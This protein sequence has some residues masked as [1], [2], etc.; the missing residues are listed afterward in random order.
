VT[1]A[2][3]GVRGVTILQNAGVMVCVLQLFRIFRKRTPPPSVAELI[4]NFVAGAAGVGLLW[5]FHA[6]ADLIDL[7]SAISLAQA[8]DPSLGMFWP[9][10][11]AAVRRLTTYRPLVP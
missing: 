10:A 7:V 1:L 3:A 2:F 6:P 8:I 11:F 9:R 4:G 5:L